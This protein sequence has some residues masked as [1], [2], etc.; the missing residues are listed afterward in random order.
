MKYLKQAP[1]IFIGPTKEQNKENLVYLDLFNFFNTY[2]VNNF[3]VRNKYIKF[4]KQNYDFIKKET[5][6]NENWFSLLTQQQFSNL[7]SIEKFERLLD[8]SE[9]ILTVSWFEINIELLNNQSKIDYFFK[10]E[11]SKSIISNL[12]KNSYPEF[13]W[14]IDPDFLDKSFFVDF[15]KSYIVIKILWNYFIKVSNIFKQLILNTN[16]PWNPLKITNKDW[17]V[18]PLAILETDEISNN[19]NKDTFKDE[20][21]I[22]FWEFKINQKLLSDEIRKSITNYRAIFKDNLEENDMKILKQ[23]EAFK[24]QS[25]LEDLEKRF[26]GTWF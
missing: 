24:K 12:L 13:V 3:E 20:L 23:E 18:Q 19:G 16:Q 11:N 15:F 1:F 8:F 17:I 6:I 25:D 4:L 2:F 9:T 10:S 14:F 5:E 22:K 7:D 26:E 21:K